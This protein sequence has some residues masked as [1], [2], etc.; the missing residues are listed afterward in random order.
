MTRR[1]AVVTGSRADFGLLSRV[2]SGLQS[3]PGVAC[4]VIVTGA[5]LSAD[6]GRTVTELEALGVP[7]AFRVDLGLTGD[8]AGDTV[9]AMGRAVSGFADAY[10]ALQ[11]D[12]VVVLGDRYEILAAACAATVACIPLA[13]LHGGEISEGAVDDAM[14]HA[15]TKLAQ[16]HFVAAEAYRQR[17]IQMGE[18]PA[19]VHLVGGMGVDLAR[20]TP[21]FTRAELERD[22]GFRFGVRNVVITFHPVTLHAAQGQA[23]LEALL[24]ALAA[25]ED[26]HLAFTLPN[27]DVGNSG[28][29]QRVESF[30]ASHPAA[31]AFSSLGFRRYLSLVASCDGVVGNSSSGLI[32]APALGIGTVNVGHRQDGRLR[33]S[34][35]IDCAP[36]RD[37][38]GAALDR[39]FSPSFR[40]SLAN[41][42]NPYGEGGAS[43]EVVR[44]LTTIVLDGLLMK[45]F[46]D[47][48]DAANALNTH[49]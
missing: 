8:S 40:A 13:H 36:T 49:V 32:E 14:R 23:E 38:I 15:I 29:R 41:V 33:A 24:D 22:T 17:V 25:L 11:P 6:H 18:D 46:H 39:L 45:R 31:W 28:I 9:R 48:P 12:V 7:I 34:S 21:R 19:R 3:A 2:I 4:Q 35:V 37:A 26:T 47:L 42:T 27:A 43:D 5:H 44:V 30:V 10:A 1:I 16:L 20:H